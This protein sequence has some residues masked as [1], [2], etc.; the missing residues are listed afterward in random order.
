[1]THLDIPAYA[2]INLSL[3]VL[4]KREDGYHELRMIMQTIELHDIVRI[5]PVPDPGIRLECSGRWVP[6][7]RTNTAWKAAELMMRQYGIK[8]GLKIT[9]SKRIP[10][11]A[12]LAGGSA[13]AAAVLR[14]LNELFSLGLDGT[15]LRELGRQIGADVPY[16]VEG[17]TK[18]AE[19]IGE[20]LTDIGDFG[21]VDIV[22]I[23]PRVGVSTAWV[24]GN[25]RVQ[26][27]REQDRPDTGL[28]RNAIEKKDAVSVAKHMRNVLE[29][30]T[31]PR[32]DIIRE[33]KERLNESG[34]LGSMMSG[35]GPTAFGI[36][37]DGES[38]AGA[39][40]ALSRDR[41]WQCYMV[42]TCNI[43]HKD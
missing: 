22:L 33:V 29:L 2:K 40:A 41:R 28:I 31:I 14:G 43:Q 8:S 7:D 20:Q 35:S 21:G 34:A 25:L 12:G 26:D 23:K 18:L 3:D 27:I 39:F 6:R 11:A 24:Y 32:Y 5:E 9:V 13:D 19:G 16:C 15:V 10:V 4:R 42:K 30:V 36:F 17:G 38:A 1:M 37:R